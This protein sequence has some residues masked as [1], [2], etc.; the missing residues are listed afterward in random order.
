MQCEEGVWLE[1]ERK[2]GSVK[3]GEGYFNKVAMSSLNSSIMFMSVERGEEVRD[4]IGFEKFFESNEF[5]PI[6]RG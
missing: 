3:E 2:F 4:S 1:F 6:I 5:S